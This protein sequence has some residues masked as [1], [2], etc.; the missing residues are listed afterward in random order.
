MFTGTGFN[1]FEQGLE[2]VQ[3]RILNQGFS[4]CPCPIHDNYTAKIQKSIGI[5]WYLIH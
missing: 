3:P 2:T 1:E 5:D 4:I